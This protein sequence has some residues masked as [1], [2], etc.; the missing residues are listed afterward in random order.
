M[1][2]KTVNL[3]SPT[4]ASVSVSAEK[5]ERLLRVG[6]TEPETKRAPAKKASSSKNDK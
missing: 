6:F 3:V 5:A 4:G 2:E 1:A